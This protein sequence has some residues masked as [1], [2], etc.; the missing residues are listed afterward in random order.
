VSILDSAKVL[1]SVQNPIVKQVSKWRDRRDRDLAQKVLIEGYRALVRAMSGDY[2][3]EELYVCPEWFQGE[4]EEALISSLCARGARLYRVSKEAF[5]KMAYRDRPEGLLGV[6]PQHHRGLDELP[7]YDRPMFYLVAEQIE[8]PGNLGAMLR[9]ADAAGVDALIL[10]DPKT[11]LYNPNVV[12][13]STG[14]LFTLPV[15]ETNSADALAWLKKHG[16]AI[17]SATPHTDKLFTDVDMTCSTAIVV[18]AEQYGL[19]D[20][21]LASCD[22]QVRLPMMG[23]ADS[24]NVA[25]ATTILLYEVLRQRLA[26]GLVSDTGMVAD[27]AH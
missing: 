26:S 21:W 2:P 8:K 20:L 12:R 7:V 13:A 27:P 11:D 24:L 5:V 14:T 19:S 15:V 10:C 18:G 3:V 17:L 6:G 1:T 22:V 25:T 9:S 4:N 23:S 16:V